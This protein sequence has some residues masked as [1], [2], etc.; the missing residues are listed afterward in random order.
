VTFTPTASGALNG[1]LT[2]TD[3]SNGVAG[4][5]ADGNL[6]GTGA[7]PLAGV[8]ASS[9][10]FGNQNQG[11]TSASQP[12]TLSNSGNARSPSPA[13]PQAPL[14][15]DQH[16]RGQ[17]RCGWL[18]YDQRDFYPNGQR[19]SQRHPD[20]YDNS[21]GVAGSKQTVSLSGTATGAPVASLNPSMTLSLGKSGGHFDERITASLPLAISATHTDDYEHRG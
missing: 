8:R 15:A 10:A 21:S 11:T 16:L 17:R 1:T 14:R 3:N 7:A 20:D 2:I 12:V 4:E 18:L 13:S 9:L 19:R 6:N 5:H